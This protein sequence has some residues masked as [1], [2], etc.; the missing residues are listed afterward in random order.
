MQTKMEIPRDPRQ[1]AL[2]FLDAFIDA[3]SDADIEIV[4]CVDEAGNP[5][6]GIRMCG[7][8]HGFTTAEARKVADV[9]E[10]TM[11]TFPAEAKTWAN[12]ILVLRAAADR[13][14]AGNAL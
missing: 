2:V 4:G 8:V 10:S 5:A 11:R 6:L 13:I 7:N 3:P 14:D 1:R 12:L 9:A